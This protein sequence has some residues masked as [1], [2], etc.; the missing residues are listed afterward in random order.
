M[1]EFVFAHEICVMRDGSNAAH[2]MLSVSLQIS[3]LQH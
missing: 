2:G 3:V 1:L